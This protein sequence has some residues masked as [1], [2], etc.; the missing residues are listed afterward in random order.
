MTTDKRIPRALLAGVALGLT[1]TVAAEQNDGAAAEAEAGAT[2]VTQRFDVFYDDRRIGTHRYEV[3]RDGD[4]TR[5]RSRA[6]FKVKLLFISAYSYEHHAN[7]LWRDGCLAR[8]EAVTDDNGERFAVTAAPRQGGLVLT[9]MAPERS[10]VRLDS[11]CP[12]TFAYWDLERLQHDKLINAQTG[13]ALDSSLSRVGPELLDGVATERYRLEAAG[14]API[15]LW[16]RERDR[17]WLRLETTRNDGTLSYR[18][19]ETR[20]EPAPAVEPV[21]GIQDPPSV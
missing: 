10:E 2:M 14:L 12:A 7:E 4:T 1:A 5:V 13:K 11:D 21:A 18:L 19:A 20:T 6:D 3:I 9:R 15:D 8:L 16:Y 17:Q